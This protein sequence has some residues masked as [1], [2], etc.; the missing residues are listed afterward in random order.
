MSKKMD[1][2]IHF[3]MPAKDQERVR[4]FYES[5]FGWQT[6]PFGPEAGDFVLAFTIETDEKTRMPKKRGAINGGFYKKTKPDEH[7]R[8]TI[9]VE[10]IREAMKKVEAAG[11]KVLGE[12]I[13]MPGV[14]LFA[15]FTD[16]EG[17]L[18]TLN[19][20]FTIKRL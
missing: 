19:Q 15:T 7:V 6:T 9:L 2:V 14:G 17:N 20:D 11:G 1:P 12:P 16:T 13:E 4:K 3:E 10:D 8:L 5:A 18:A